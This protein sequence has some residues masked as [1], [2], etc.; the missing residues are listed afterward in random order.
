MST[1]EISV[2]RDKDNDVLYVIRNDADKDKTLNHSLTADILL[3]LDRSTNKIV[4]L[5]IEDFST[6]LP[7]LKDLDDYH[8]MERF[9]AILEFLNASQF[10][11]CKA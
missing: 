2:N 6:V 5:T 1:G 11:H 3:R 7:D 4:G 9:D 10:S 8:L